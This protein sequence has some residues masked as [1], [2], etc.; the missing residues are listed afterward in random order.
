MEVLENVGIKV[1]FKARKILRLIAA[2]KDETIQELVERLAIQ[3]WAKVRE[4]KEEEDDYS[5]REEQKF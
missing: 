1:T 2:T 3:E 4:E 5:G